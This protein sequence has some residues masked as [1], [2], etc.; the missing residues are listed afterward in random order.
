MPSQE[1]LNI[2]EGSMSTKAKEK[3]SSD[4]KMLASTS[5]PAVVGRAQ[6]VVRVIGNHPVRFE[7]IRGGR[8]AK[9]AAIVVLEEEQSVFAS[10]EAAQDLAREVL[11][12]GQFRVVQFVPAVAGPSKEKGAKR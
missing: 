2:L 8:K 10:F 4:A 1:A 3:E 11:P 9:Y 6:F 12:W 7:K 5:A